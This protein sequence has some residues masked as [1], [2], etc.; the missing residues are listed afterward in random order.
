[1]IETLLNLKNTNTLF[2]DRDGVINKHRINDYV[3]DWKEFEFLPGVLEAMALLN[4]Y[5]NRIFIVTNQRGVGKKIMSELDLIDI[6]NRMLSTIRKANG[7]I[8]KIYYCTEMDDS[9][10]NRKPNPGMAYQ[11]KSDYPEIE[12]NQCIMVGDSQSDIE[13][14]NRLGMTTLLINQNG[15]ESGLLNFAKQLEYKNLHL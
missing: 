1:M 7:R 10:L 9:N 13:F 4:L 8:D 15:E 5:F 12:F 6:N 3:K 14:G 2:L 11:A